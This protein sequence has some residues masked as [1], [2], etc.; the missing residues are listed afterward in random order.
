MALGKASGPSGIVT[1]IRP[2]GSAGVALTRDLVD[3]I[4]RGGCIPTEWEER[5]I[6]SLYKGKGDALDS[7]NFRGLKLI[8]QI[9]GVFERFVEILIRHQIQIDDM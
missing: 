2:N 7:C 4:V 9:M 8:N 6:I 3:V 1:E 5:Y